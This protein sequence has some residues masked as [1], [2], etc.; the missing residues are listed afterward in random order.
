[1]G[2][3]TFPIDRAE[4][5]DN[6]GR[7]RYLSRDEFVDAL[8][9]TGTERVVDLGSGTGFF[10]DELAPFVGRIHAVDVQAAMHDRYAEK[11]IPANVVPVTSDIESMPFGDD[12]FDAAVTT[13]TYHEFFG[14]SALAEIHRVLVSD[15][16]FVIADWSREGLGEDGPSVE[17]R[18]S[19]A[20]ATTDL[21]AAGF[22]VEWA[23]ER[24]ETFLLV[25]TTK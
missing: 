15:A 8:E 17:E 9:P 21:E 13:M 10:T 2:Y 19:A 24:P 11:G 7:Y 14:E 1:M 12:R 18:C 16:R 20:S 6:V 23:R 5:L 22:T 3:H 4:H 25:A